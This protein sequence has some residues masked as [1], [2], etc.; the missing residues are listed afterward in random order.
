MQYWRPV[1]QA[2]IADLLICRWT[3]ENQAPDAVGYMVVLDRMM[4]GAPWSA[5]K[6]A[7]YAGWSRWKATQT[8]A[9]AKNFASTWG[10]GQPPVTVGYQPYQTNET[11]DIAEQPSQKPA[12][13]Q[14]ETSHHGR[15]SYK[16]TTKQNRKPKHTSSEIDV[17][18]EEMETVRLEANP[19]GKRRKVGGRR[20]TLQLRVNEHGKDAVLHAWVWFW[21][22]NDRRA[23]Y[24][25]DEGYG[26]QTFL[27]A[28]NLRDYIDKA[29]DWTHGNE[30]ALGWFD[31]DDFDD[32]GNL[33]TLKH[34]TQE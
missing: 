16:N 25:R 10:T 28:G 30:T 13:E 21:N 19:K 33:V 34:N 12:K 17:V 7:T 2:L 11:N 1:P 26:V 27:R 23:R 8:L 32:T 18:W 3:K 5:R 14:P 24:L 22:S 20:H 15:G 9:Q 29:S 31:D 4:A 6:L